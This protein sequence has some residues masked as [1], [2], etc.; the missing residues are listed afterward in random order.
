MEAKDIMYDVIGLIE[1]R[2]EKCPCQHALG[3][4]HRFVRK[5]DSPNRTLAINDVWPNSSSNNIRCLRTNIKLRR[6]GVGGVLYG[7]D[8]F[9]AKIGYRRTAEE[10][11]IGTHG[12]G[13][14]EQGGR[15]HELVIS[16]HI[17]RDNSHFQKPS[18]LR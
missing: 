1:T 15:L 8:D 13:W 3:H 18:H 16:T 12:M 9:N 4:V 5:L 11:H 10:L 7:S 2:E 17:K 6:R 14:N